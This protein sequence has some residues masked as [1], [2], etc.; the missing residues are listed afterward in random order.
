[1]LSRVVSIIHTYAQPPKFTVSPVLYVVPAD[2]SPLA[3]N[4][5]TIKSQFAPDAIGAAEPEAIS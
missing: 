5:G 4:P 1:V 3:L 2:Q